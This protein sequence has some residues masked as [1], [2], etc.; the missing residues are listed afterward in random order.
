MEPIESGIQEASFKEYSKQNRDN[1]LIAHQVPISKLGGSESSSIASA[2]SQ[3][4]T[5]K[6]QVS[7]PAQSHLAKIVNKIV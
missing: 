1:I 2:L 7:R 3:D 4:R 5:F 6:E